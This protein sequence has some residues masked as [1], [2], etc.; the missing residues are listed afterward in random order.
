MNLAP[1]AR[2]GG[3]AQKVAP[4]DLE[5]QLKSPNSL[6]M[7]G[8]VTGKSKK[9]PV[10][11]AESACAERR[12]HSEKRIHSPPKLEDTSRVGEVGWTGQE[13]LGAR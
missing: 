12:T 4:R 11:A 13:V 7:Q 5:E 10:C 6:L 1:C 8:T 9:W 2:E 3:D